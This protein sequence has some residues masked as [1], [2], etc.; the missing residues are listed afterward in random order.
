MSDLMFPVVEAVLRDERDLVAL[1]FENVR[2]Q[3]ADRI[4]DVQFRVR[5]GPEAAPE[6]F[7]CA[8]AHREPAVAL[9]S[10]LDDLGRAVVGEISALRHDPVADG[11]SIELK[12]G[13]L[14]GEGG[15][16]VVVWLDLCRVSPATRARA[17]RGR[18]QSGLRFFTTRDRLEDFRA[19]LAQLV[20]GGP[21]IQ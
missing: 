12:A 18:H 11:V 6:P 19:Q 15:Y 20:E 21:S 4:F 13:G 10:L 17:T 2:S 7:L 9:S 8:T 16:Q 3:G 14:A 5:Q 1:A